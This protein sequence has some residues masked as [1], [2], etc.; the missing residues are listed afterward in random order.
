MADQH[1]EETAGGTIRLPA[2]ERPVRQGFYD[3]VVRPY[4]PRYFRTC[5]PE[6]IEYWRQAIM[7]VATKIIDTSESG[8]AR[9]RGIDDVNPERTTFESPAA[10]TA[11][12][13]RL[14]LG[15]G[16]DLVGVTRFKE[17]YCFGDSEPDGDYLVVVAKQMEWEAVSQAPAEPAGVEMARIYAL[18]GRAV[19]ELAAAIRALGYRA[20]AHHP[21]SDDG[22]FNGGSILFIPA[23]VDA[24]LGW[25][26]RCTSMVTEQFGPRVR[27]GAV[28]TELPLAV[29]TPMPEGLCGSCDDCIRACPTKALWMDSLKKVPRYAVDKHKFDR[30]RPFYAETHG[31]GVCLASCPFSR[32]FMEHQG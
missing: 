22:K 2:T 31:C 24:G 11:H 6:G 15:F 7:D 19:I 4:N 29:D 8:R 18:V 14:A 32:R 3:I 1:S 16:G 27:L 9:L 20:R 13:K 25:M 5:P 17:E 10:A 23:A 30:C 28:A 26:G 12:V 21:M